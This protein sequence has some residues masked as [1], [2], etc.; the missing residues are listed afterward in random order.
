MA[1][2]AG[3]SLGTYEVLSFIGAGGMGEVYLARDRDLNRTVAIKVLPPDL[4]S[5]AHRVARFEQEARSASALN[6]PNVC[7]IYALGRTDDDRRFIAMERIEGET[8]RHRLA[9]ERLPV[10]D[11]LDIAIQIASGLAAAHAAGI[12]HR[13]IK[14]E[15]V[16]IRRDRLVKILD[17][18]LAKLMPSGESLAAHEP[19]RT[20][21]TDAGSVVGTVAYMSP[22]QTRATEVDARTDIWALGVVL[23]EM[24]AGRPPFT[25]ASRSDVLVAILEREPA[26]LARFDPHVPGELQRIVT[27]ALQKDRSRRYQ[28]VQDLLL[29]LQA[30]RDDLRSQTG[31]P[32]EEHAPAS[33]DPA[34]RLA[35]STGVARQK[36]LLRS[37]RAAMGGAIVLLFLA[38]GWAWWYKGQSRRAA[39]RPADPQVSRNLTRLTF[40]PGLQTDMT[41]S[42]DGT[43][44]A[45][46]AD[47]AGNFDIWEQAVSGGQPVQFTRSPAHDIQPAWS[48]DGRAIVFRSER[49]GGGLFTVP[50]GGG[51]ERQLTS[52]GVFPWWAPDGSEILFRA[53]SVEGGTSSLHAVSPHGGEQ[54]RE[55]LHEFL[56]D[57]GWFWIASHPD[58]RISA[59]GLHRESGLGFYTVSRDGRTIAQST[60]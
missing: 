56:S 42:P 28:T 49:D 35:N 45:Y 37:R 47:S 52:F 38:A 16:M 41:W 53:G 50:V 21:L 57:G 19:T 7:V 39:V 34:R 10:R 33:A 11:V 54:P 6:H 32:L 4:T 43:R 40:A 51:P 58:G 36:P 59:L 27:K 12:V 23:Y 8:L 20:L 24:V 1:L 31:S 9:G 5:D 26:P 17:F 2:P 14:P 22:E 44:I 29:D 30:L 3:T 25:G 60:I 15:N 46:A 55:V 13:D 48:P 18:G